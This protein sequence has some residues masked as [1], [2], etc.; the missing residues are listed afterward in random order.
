M[1]REV[2]TDLGHYMAE[3]N[4]EIRLKPSITCLTDTDR[5]AS[6][7]EKV[8]RWSR[9]NLHWLVLLPDLR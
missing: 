6:Q 2:Q 9:L 1:T 5:G 4:S 3:V 7:Q 8:V